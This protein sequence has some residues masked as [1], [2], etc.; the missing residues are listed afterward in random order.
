MY[1]MS[2]DPELAP[3]KA[4]KM[5]PRERMVIVDIFKRSER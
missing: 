2:K 1:I 5:Q 3:K 4:L